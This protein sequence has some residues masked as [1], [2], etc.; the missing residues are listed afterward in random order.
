MELQEVIETAGTCRYF[1]PDPI[2]DD[3]L[4]RVLN[5]ARFAPSGGNRQPWRFIVVKDPAKRR[6][7]KE[8]YLIPWK[9]YL[10][11][12]HRGEIRVGSPQQQRAI[13]AADYF[14]EHMDV[15]P[16]IVVVCARLADVHITDA[17][18]G[19]PSIVGGCSVYTS[20]QNMFLKAREEGLGAAI[21]TLLC[22]FEPQ[23]KE[24]LEIPEELS[25]ACHVVLGWPARPLPRKLT[26]APLHEIAFV[27][28]YGNPF[29]P[30]QQG[31]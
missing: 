15:A 21:T 12:V 25:T 1:R 13:E 27:D 26:R 11:A 30:P 16:V 19:R 3:V 22:H 29:Y 5:A 31:S 7:L 20:V 2:P 4:A 6:Q 9:A 18:L 8:W 24:L 14:A 28:R 10:Q 23:V 17:E